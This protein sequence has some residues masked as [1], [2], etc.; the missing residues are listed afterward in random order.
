M[1][2]GATLSP[3]TQWSPR[4]KAGYVQPI[5]PNLANGISGVPG[6]SDKNSFFKLF[7][8]TFMVGSLFIGPEGPE[9]VA[10][11]E[12]GIGSFVENNGFKFSEK[13]Y[14]KLWE[15]GRSAPGFRTEAII[16]SATK[17]GADPRGMPGFMNYVSET[18]FY[19]PWN[20][21]MNPVTRE[22]WH[23]GPY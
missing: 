14:Q 11:V 21:I 1:G 6:G 16:N 3:A 7:N 15:T 17:V 9:G 22:V 18:A 19:K 12:G 8:G 5:T 13:Y 10:G 20:V 2:G 23:I 4:S